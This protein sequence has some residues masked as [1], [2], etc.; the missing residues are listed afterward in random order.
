MWLS[1]PASLGELWGF[2]SFHSEINQMSTTTSKKEILDY[3]WDWTNIFGNWAKTLVKLVVQKKVALSYDERNEIYD[4]FL[5][6]ILN[7]NK[8]TSEPIQKP[9]LDSAIKSLQLISLSEIKGVNRLAENQT[10]TFGKNLTVIYGENASGKSG[11]S[12]ILKAFGF[13]YEKGSPILCNVYD[14][15]SSDQNAKINYVL[16]GNETQFTWD[17][18]CTTPDLQKISVFTNNCVNISLGSKRELIVTPIGFH[19]FSLVSNELDAL[20]VIHKEKI[21]SFI[22]AIDWLDDLHEE[23][24]VYEFLKDL[25][26]KSSKD[27]LSELAEYTDIEKKE[28]LDLKSKKRNLN[29]DLLN[30]Q[31][32][33]LNNQLRELENL[34]TKIQT[35]KI[36]FSLTNWNKMQSDL[37]QIDKLLKKEQKGIGEVASDR[38]VEYYESNEFLNFIKAADDYIKILR[39]DDYPKDQ[40]EVCIYC[41]QRLIDK[42]SQELLK[43]YR[44]LLNDTTQAELKEHK[45]SYS[46]LHTKLE[47][48]EIETT[49]HYPS[50]GKNNEGHPIQPDFLKDHDD[51][52]KTYLDIANGKDIDK[53]KKFPFNVDYE[54]ITTKL[55]TK[56]QYIR[57]ELA[58]KKQTLFDLEKKEIEYTRKIEKLLD[59]KKLNSK[60][61]KVEKIIDGLKI[62]EFLKEY[63]KIFNT[64]TISRIASK[65]RNELIAE[66]FKDIFSKE[67]KALRKSDINVNLNFKTDKAVPYLVQDIANEISLS[68]VLSEGE[69]K[70]IALSE[71]LTELQLDKNSAAVVFDD[72]VTSLDHKI[73]D[74][75]ARRLVSL[76]KNRQVIIF[77]H[78]IILLNSIKHMSELPR[79]KNLDFLYYETETDFKSTGILNETPT[80]REETYKNYSSKINKILNLSKEERNRRESELAIDGYGKL[81]AC[82]EIIIEKDIF[83]ES[84]KRYRKNVAL[85][86]L[87]K[88]NGSLID[89]HKE[90]LYDVFE[91]CCGYIDAHS[92]PDCV[93]SQ[94]T[95]AELKID[96]EDVKNIRSEF[97][98]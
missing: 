44:L 71:F 60:I 78:S 96:F 32:E 53:F 58:Q 34:N 26:Y 72:P 56:I 83:K 87:E 30:E 98:N 70:A 64:I 1:R 65:A 27:K 6:S 4:I 76:S 31:I 77:T 66:N 90:N 68:D 15:T 46:R 37:K 79:F 42:N 94:P 75:V 69:Q 19:L 48:I 85:T 39:K 17:G 22:I 51:K 95:L 11:Y 8:S 23:T 97:L 7:Q 89:K 16:D 20:S 45:T 59:R 29:K 61:S 28:L 38:G 86:A 92:N 10:L 88:V 91:K 63:S 80:L 9:Y 12:R 21:S 47:Q 84:I 74:E 18:V 13:S 2:L 36:Q 35:N 3:L 49:L 54:A 14:S 82:I 62:S 57:T 93:P 50:F 33:S 40:N 55:M 41:R 67:L 24:P 73:I 52:I 81:R 5:N 25:S 43:C